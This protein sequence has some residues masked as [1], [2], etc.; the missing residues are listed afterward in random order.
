MCIATTDEILGA[1]L[2]REGWPTYTDPE[3][4]GL[5][6]RGGPTKGGITLNTLSSWRG[7]RAARRD[8]KRLTREEALQILRRQFVECN[9]IARLEGSPVFAQVIDNGVLS[10]PYTAVCDLQRAL[11]V[12][13]DGIIG[14]IT[15]AAVEAQRHRISAL[16]VRARALRIA[17]FVQSHPKQLVFLNGWMTRILSFLEEG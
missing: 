4:T 3:E 5:P 9:G 13:A 16:L 10:G 1:I 6:D 11:G 8:L 15:C 14:G 2:E 7:H 17:R 12:T